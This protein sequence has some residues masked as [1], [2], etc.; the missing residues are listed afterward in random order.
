MIKVSKAVALVLTFVFLCTSGQFA[1]ANT[2]STEHQNARTIHLDDHTF[3]N[4]IPSDFDPLKASDEELKTYGIPQRPSDPKKLKQWEKE[5]SNAKWV[6][7]TI[8]EVPKEIRLGNTAQLD[9]DASI[10]NSD[11]KALTNSSTLDSIFSTASNNWAGYVYGSTAYGASADVTVPSIYAPSNYRPASCAQWVGTGGNSSTALAQ[12]GICE[13]VSSVGANSYFAWYETIGT[14]VSSS[15]YM[16]SSF[17][18]SPKDDVYFSMYR[19]SASSG[20]NLVYYMHNNTKGTYTSITVNVTSYSG[21]SSSA[22]WIFERPANASGLDYLASPTNATGYHTV[23]F[24]Q[25]GYK[26]TASIWQDASGTAYYLYDKTFTDIIA[27]ETYLGV[28]SFIVSWY[29]YN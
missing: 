19:E 29:D 22:E 10:T 8:E 11:T 27:S 20:I 23:S 7:P 28:N 17:S 3:Y 25:C 15:A 16:F 14:N 12:C 26:D 2:T 21:I 24:T 1:S 18:V 9:N 5:V 13:S 6:E 4:K